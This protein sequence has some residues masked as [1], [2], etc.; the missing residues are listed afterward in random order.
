MEIPRTRINEW[1]LFVP[2]VR[3]HINTYANAQYGDKGTDQLTAFTPAD[4]KAQLVRYTNRIGSGVRGREEEL[5][6]CLKMAH[7]SCA[8]YWKY[9]KEQEDVLDA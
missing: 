4:I 8:L 9:L 1:E 3:E 6:D 5:R 7:Y 2:V